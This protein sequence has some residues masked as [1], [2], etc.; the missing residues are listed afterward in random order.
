MLTGG[1]FTFG[2]A[3]NSGRVLML[4]LHLLSAALL[5]DIA[6][7]QSKNVIAAS[8]AVLIFSLSPLA[9]YFQ[10][11]V[12]LDN[13]MVFW[14]LLAVD[15]VIKDKRKLFH[16][17]ISA[18][19]FG[20]AVLTKESALFFFPAI[21]YI[22]VTNSNE[23][24]RSFAI[25]SWLTIF[26]TIVS[27]YVLLALLKGEFFPSG[28]PLGGSHPHASLL[29]SI[30]QQTARRGGFFLDPQSTF[31]TFLNEWIRGGEFI[32]FG[33]APLIIGGGIATALALVLSINDQKLRYAVLLLLS[34][35]AFLIS[36]FEISVLYVIPLVPLL[37]LAIALSIHRLGETLGG[38]SSGGIASAILAGAL[39]FPFA[40]YYATQPANYIMDHTTRQ[41]DAV[42]WIDA[43]I[44]DDAL[45]IIDNYAFVDLQAEGR[46]SS[47]AI[48][49]AYYYWTAETD[50]AIRTEIL[51][52]N[53]QNVDYIL[54]SPQMVYDAA[55][56]GLALTS[57]AQENSVPVKTFSNNGWD[58]EVREVM[59][60]VSEDTVPK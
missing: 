5:Y 49:N 40:R 6:R 1:F 53:W 50:S 29:A 37:A 9:V 56:E 33:D 32:E 8:V 15:M 44:S 42:H 51:E 16:Y 30:G 48:D 12:L 17:A 11:R 52:D 55:E 36:G 13:I 58:I 14:L 19:A 59:V 54:L 24:H 27:Y 57:D 25:G 45:L 23:Y 28:T 7:S 20:M 22:V 38:A 26:L 43:N 2:F 31:V 3:I 39:L 46:V 35:W 60:D 10:R 21:L 18:I 4:I 41:I 47:K 34:Y